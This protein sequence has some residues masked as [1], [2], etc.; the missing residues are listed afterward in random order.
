MPV[1]GLHEAAKENNCCA[2]IF[3]TSENRKDKTVWL[4]M[5]WPED[6]EPTELLEDLKKV[7]WDDSAMMLQPL[8]TFGIKT[9]SVTA[10]GTGLFNHFQGNE[11]RN[12][13]QRARRVLRKHGY[14]GVG[15]Y[16]LTMADMM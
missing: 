14:E 12:A 1:P 8:V 2:L 7:G 10:K 9:M 4:E 11:K 3:A 16:T 15:V 5:A 13:M 6:Q